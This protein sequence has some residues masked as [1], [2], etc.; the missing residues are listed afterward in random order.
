MARPLRN[1]AALD[2]IIGAWSKTLDVEALDAALA[3][4]E[5]PPDLRDWPEIVLDRTANVG[6]RFNLDTIARDEIATWKPG[7]TL[8]L[9]GHLLTRRD[10]ACAWCG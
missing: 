6:R 4:A 8:L 2:L 5:E 9:S 3:G 1:M 7:D 10:V